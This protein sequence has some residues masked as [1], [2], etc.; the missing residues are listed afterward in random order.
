M[1]KSETY[2]STLDQSRKDIILSTSIITMLSF[3]L[4]IFL[5]ATSNLMVIVFAIQFVIT[6]CFFT[7]R[8]IKHKDSFIDII[9]KKKFGKKTQAKF[10]L[11]FIVL[12]LV[13]S[14]AY[15]DNKTSSG[16]FSYIVMLVP[17]FVSRLLLYI[18][19]LPLSTLYYGEIPKNIHKHH[20]RNYYIFSTKWDFQSR[21]NTMTSPSYSSLPGNTYHSSS[22]V[23]YN[24]NT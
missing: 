12:F 6:F 1:N 3:L 18:K 8:A 17:L 24:H 2:F 21:E 13:C 5:L 11:L 19:N 15:A 22:S 20:K 10:L 4:F 16:F 14:T 9:S 7:N 23:T